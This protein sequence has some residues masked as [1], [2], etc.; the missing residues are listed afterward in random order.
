[1]EE[2]QY[3]EI[4]FDTSEDGDY[5]SLPE[6]INLNVNLT[7]DVDPDAVVNA[8]DSSN[9]GMNCYDDNDNSFVGDGDLDDDIDDNLD[10]NSDPNDDLDDNLDSNS[11][12]HDDLDDNLD[13]NF[14]GNSDPDD[15][16]DS[17]DY[18]IEIS[19]LCT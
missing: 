2:T 1:M 11:D 5:F 10:G 6:N 13:D 12:L 17:N 4:E 18:D 3:N 7:D 19:K 14:D 15:E 9:C 16:I 8:G